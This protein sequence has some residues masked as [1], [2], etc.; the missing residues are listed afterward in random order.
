MR[1]SLTNS[2]KLTAKFSIDLAEF[3]Q[4]DGEDKFVSRIAAELS[5]EE[6]RVKVVGV[7]GDPVT[8]K[9]FIEE[10]PPPVE[11]ATSHDNSATSR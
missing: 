9:A 7:Y 11:V 4:S 8:I 2:I 3:Y 10:V 6:D 5:I 1:V